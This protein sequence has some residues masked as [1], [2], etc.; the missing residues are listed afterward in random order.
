MRI[1]ISR[2]DNFNDYDV[3]KAECQRIVNY[4]FDREDLF[5]Y[6]FMTDVEIIS[7]GDRRAEDLEIRFAK[8]S[9]LN[10]IVMKADPADVIEYALASK[11]KNTMLISFF[12]GEEGETA[13]IVRLAKEKG[14]PVWVKAV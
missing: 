5:G 12:D 10:S 11:D 4:V 14:I 2:S 7:N 9:R 8:E 13:N 3:L 6:V 1:M